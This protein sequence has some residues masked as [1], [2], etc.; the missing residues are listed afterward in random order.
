MNDDGINTD[1]LYAGLK[2]FADAVSSLRKT[3]AQVLPGLIEIGKIFGEFALWAE[4]V[5]KMAN[6]QIVFTD[7]FT[8]ELAHKF[9]EEPDIVQAVDRYYYEGGH[10]SPLIETL[11]Q[12]DG[13]EMYQR[14]Y[15]EIIAAFQQEHYQ[16]ACTGLFSLA[17]G[18]LADASDMQGCVNYEK[19]IKKIEERISNNE[20]L[21]GLDRKFW[22]VYTGLNA[23]TGTMFNGKPFTEKEEDLLNRNWLQHGRTH[24]TY[25]R[26]DFLKALLLVDG[27]LFFA[28]Q[29]NSKSQIEED[30]A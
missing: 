16:L 15:E 14:F 25:T 9:C 5:D 8:L 12:H 19:R 4:A 6:A 11:K 26:M 10:I 28:E 29:G 13:M 18:I 24:R 17:D 23:V 2:A 7:D 20:E 22:C 1:G 21:T 27:I 3:V 30:K